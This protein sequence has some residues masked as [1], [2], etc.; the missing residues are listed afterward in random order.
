MTTQTS[1]RPERRLVGVDDLRP[2]GTPVLTI[3]VC[4]RCAGRWFPPREVCSACAHD[5]LDPVEAGP[6]GVAYASTV[7][8]IGAPG[9]PTP[10]V[11]TYV[12][13]DGVRLLAHTDTAHTDSTDPSDPA[14]LAPGTP[15][16]LT[17]GPTGTVGGVEL[18]SYRVRPVTTPEG[19]R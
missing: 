10:Y 17:A 11:L 6:E 1:G 2:D 9:F 19:D 8:R 3:S 15:V 16:V 7:V 14:P 13:V 12:D 4:A 5:A 18:W